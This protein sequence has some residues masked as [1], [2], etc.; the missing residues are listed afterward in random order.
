MCKQ[1]SSMNDGNP[2]VLVLDDTSWWPTRAIRM[3]YKLFSSLTAD[4]DL[5][6]NRWELPHDLWVAPDELSKLILRLFC[7]VLDDASL[8]L[9]T[10]QRELPPRDMRCGTVTRWCNPCLAST[11]F[12]SLHNLMMAG[13]RPKALESSD[14]PGAR[15]VFLRHL[16]EQV[17]Y[18]PANSW[19]PWQYSLSL[20]PPPSW[21]HPL[22]PRSTCR[23]NPKGR[24][25]QS[26]GLH[27]CQCLHGI[28]KEPQGQVRVP[29]LHLANEGSLAG[30]YLWSGHQAGWLAGSEVCG[31]V[32][33]W[34]L[35]LLHGKPSS[36]GQMLGV[37]VLGQLG[38][39]V[40]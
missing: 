7:F 10:K 37:L 38:R 12:W 18:S 9:R 11:A 36:Q 5:G 26:V 40:C 1:A 23:C 33:E 28:A 21:L 8:D 2:H 25:A 3:W 32:G 6:G 19:C 30:A 24:G 27:H 17:K 35:V 39:L 34:T 16:L 20:F 4:S 29:K 31:L 15:W 14:S 13:G 22:E